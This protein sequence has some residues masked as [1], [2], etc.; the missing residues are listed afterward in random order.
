MIKLKTSYVCLKCGYQ[1]P[2]WMGKCPECN[3]WN[4]FEEVE[5]IKDQKSSKDFI[6]NENL[7]DCITL[8]NIN[9]SDTQRVQTNSL[10]LNRVLG[11]GIVNGSVI[12]LAGDPGIGKS[13][14][15]LQVLCQLSK[16]NKVLYISGEESK[17]Q[18]KQRA[19]RLNVFQDNLLILTE[20]ILE[21]IINQIEKEKPQFIAIDSIQTLYKREHS[22]VPGSVPQIRECTAAL[23]RYA[24][25]NDCSIFVVGHVTKEGSIA[26]PRILE[27]MVD[28]VLYF[29]GDKQHEYRLLR[30]AK[31]RFGS[32]NELGVFQMDEQGMQDIFNPS[33]ALISQRAANVS[34]SIVFC[35]SQGSRPI[36]VDLQSLTCKSFYSMPKRMVNGADQSRLSLL[37]AVLEKRAGFKLYDQ[38]VYV[39][40]AGG[41]NINDPASDLALILAI[42][43]SYK[44]KA[45]Q[46]GMTAIGE[47]GLCGEVRAVSYAQRRINECARLGY[48]T[49]MLPRCLKNKIKAV[50]NTNLLFVDTIA[51]AISICF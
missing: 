34:G 19:N 41:I 16:N 2:K 46:Q 27:H 9:T 37:I 26:G 28:V 25:S 21:R 5:E 20:T 48:K 43:S 42:A 40:V 33:E 12:L 14:L 47:V 35:A 3:S 11:G 18:I 44:N 6:F 39:N 10:E 1:T 24:K 45:L 31:N 36:L 4:S 30:A 50:D 15:L 7:D 49:I 29:E 17:L 51:Q 38:D 13:T 8:A 22:S 32:V 23:I